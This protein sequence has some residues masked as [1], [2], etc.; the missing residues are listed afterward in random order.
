[1][2]L[3]ER[4]NV[5]LHEAMR[6]NDTV[7]KLAIRAVKAALTEA[8]VAGTE[9]KALTDQEE[10]AIVARQIKQRRDS[11]EEFTKG[12]RP[13]LVAEEEA[14]IAVLLEYMPPQLD[15][16]GIRARAR[17]VI[18]ELGVSDLKGIGPVMRR[19]SAD[20]RGQADGQLV[21]RIVRELLS[22]PPQGQSR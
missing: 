1:M 10:L 3:E 18:A 11:I 14:E 4:L 12:N 20:L 15:E 6:K 2:S 19:L 9:A 21:N 5:E 7:R 13:D 22:V 8:K 17:A 16:N